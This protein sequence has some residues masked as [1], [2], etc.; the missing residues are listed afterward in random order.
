MRKGLIALIA[1]VGILLTAIIGFRIYSPKQTTQQPPVVRVGYKQNS[2]YQHFFVAEEKGYFKKHGINVEGVT[3][4]STNQM[5][6]AMVNGDIDATAASS[7]EVLALVEQNS[8]DLI[9]IYLT[10]VFDKENAFHSILVPPNSKI[11]TLADLKGKKIGT[12]PGST[13]Q[14]WLEIVLSRFFDSKKEVQIIQ[15]EPRL[16]LQA[17]SSGQVDALYTVDPLV[18]LSQTKGVARILMKGPE[19]EYMFTPMAT[20]G[21]AVSRRL[22][23]K[24]PEAAKGLIRAMYDAVDFMRANEPESRQ[25]IAK[26]AKLDPDVAAK[27]DLLRLWKLSE[28]DFKMVQKYLDLLVETKVLTKHI[29][30]E[31]LYLNSSFIQ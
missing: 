3:F 10:L 17:L 26:D 22:I 24:N 20:G 28:T 29:V 2:G 27:L 13:S 18:T 1:V 16:Q 21:A 14:S 30:A 4:E 11:Q 6:Q 23:Q 9:D 31:D 12:T 5:V 15:L 19:N 25:I 8:P 7:I